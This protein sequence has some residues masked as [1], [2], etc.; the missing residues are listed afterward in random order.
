MKD[1]RVTFFRKTLEELVESLEATLRVTRWVGPEVVPEPLKES[2]S[3]LVTRLGT[4]DRLASG[5]FKGSPSDSAR[6]DAMLGAMRRL[7]A[8]YVAYRK[9]LESTPNDSDGAAAALDIEIGEVKADA[10]WR[11]S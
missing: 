2:A 1:T 3:R 10:S 6:V 7:D 5:V 8:A 11:E 9:R 4:A